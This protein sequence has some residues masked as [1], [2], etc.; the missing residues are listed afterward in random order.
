FIHRIKGPYQ[1]IILEKPM[2]IGKKEDIVPYMEEYNRLLEKHVREDP[3]QWFWMHK[4]WKLTPVKKIMV[5]DDGKKGHLKQSLAVIKQLKRYRQSEGFTPEQ[6]PV[7]IVEI[8]FKSKAAKTM[9]NLLNPII[10]FNCQ[11]KARRLAPFLEGKSYEDAV[12]R[13]ADVIISCGSTLSGVNRFLKIENN[14]RNLTVLDPGTYNRRKFDLVVVPK[15]DCL[16]KNIKGK[17]IVVTDLA[18]NTVH[19]EELVSLMEPREGVGIGLLLGGD[20]PYFHFGGGLMRSVTEGIKGACERL[21]GHLYM[22]TSRRTPDAAETIAK[23]AFTGY[24]RCARFISGREDKDEYTVEKILALSD[25]VVVSGES[26]SMVSE[27][28]SSGKPVLVFMP[29]KKKSRLTK[30]EKFAKD[31]ERSKYLKIVSPEQIPDEAER[32]VSGHAEHVLP[33]DNERIFEKM[34]KLF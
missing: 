31:L 32:F 26:I 9:F 20:N 17:N 18:P 11:G 1:K 27:A 29:D 2:V 8:R 12:S 3:E 16:A 4:K 6:T 19:P 13:Y 14:A 25:V 24:P 21:N 33:D 10:T 23:E 15:H 5:L 28:V 34:Y 30:Y 22:T 7:D